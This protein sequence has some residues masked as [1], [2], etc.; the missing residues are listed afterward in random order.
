MATDLELAQRHRY[1]TQHGRAPAPGVTSIDIIEK[2]ALPW[3][4]ANIAAQE[5]VLNYPR[6]GEIVQATRAKR[7]RALLR[8]IVV[9]ATYYDNKVKVPVSEAD[10]EDVYAYWARGRFDEVWRA[11]ADRGSRVHAHAENWVAGI[12]IT[13][14]DDEAGYINALERFWEECEPE[15]HHSE[16]IVVNPSPEGHDDW[17]YGGRLDMFATL[18]KGPMQGIFLGDWK[19]GGHYRGPVALQSAGYLGAKFAT[20]LPNGDL[21]PLEDLPKVDTAID[22]YLH[23]DGTYKIIDAFSDIPQPIAWDAFLHLRAVLNFK[24]LTDKLDKEEI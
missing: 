11:K 21:G 8:P 10:P 7:G 15:F 2:G 6:M 23:V 12:P 9:D 18:H 4:A 13:P 24:K 20:Y 1:V 22:I 14:L 3:G 16:R 5:A 19:T 17:E